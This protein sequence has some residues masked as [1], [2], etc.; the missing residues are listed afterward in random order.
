MCVCRGGVSPPPPFPSRL[1]TVGFDETVGVIGCLALT[2]IW[3]QG[4]IKLKSQ[5]ALLAAAVLSGVDSQVSLL[6]FIWMHARRF[7]VVSSW[8]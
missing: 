1:D 7:K 5:A 3:C 6:W 8:T 4:V 2:Q